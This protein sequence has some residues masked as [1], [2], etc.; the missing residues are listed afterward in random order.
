MSTPAPSGQP[1]GRNMVLAKSS[2]RRPVSDSG[3]TLTNRGSVEGGK[4]GKVEIRPPPGSWGLWGHRGAVCPG[5]GMARG[6]RPGAVL[7]GPARRAHVSARV[8]PEAIRPSDDQPGPHAARLAAPRRRWGGRLGG[9]RP[10][11]C[12]EREART[13]KGP[14]FSRCIP[15]DGTS[16][17]PDAMQRPVAP[18]EQVVRTTHRADRGDP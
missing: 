15:G 3:G 11:A 16:V 13:N 10:A 9:V 1:R 4:L 8:G 7:G 17:V 14:L 12:L 5:A 2:H 18:V 6:S